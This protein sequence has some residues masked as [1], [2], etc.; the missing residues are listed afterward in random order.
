[1]SKKLRVQKTEEKLPE[2][3]KDSLGKTLADVLTA[4]SNGEHTREVAQKAA[5]TAVQITP[6]ECKKLCTKIGVEYKSGYESRV[7]AYVC[8]DESVDRYGDIIKQDGWDLTAFKS[9]PVV[10]GFHNY[11]TFPVGNSIKTWTEDNKLK[12]WILF[13]DKDVNEDA[14]IAFRMAKSGFMKAGSVGFIPKDVHHPKQEER[15]A[16]GMTPWGVVFQKQELLEHTVCGVPANS[17][18]LQEAV[19]KGIASQKE[20]ERWTRKKEPT[21]TPEPE[22]EVKTL[23]YTPSEETIKTIE[24]LM[25]KTFEKFTEEKAGAVLSK[26]NKQL[27]GNAIEAMAS[28]QKA[29]QSLL[30][31]VNPE[32][33]TEEDQKDQHSKDISTTDS[34]LL[35]DDE[36][37]DVDDM[38]GAITTL[39]LAT[40]ELKDS[41]QGEK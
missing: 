34:D 14:D 6:E 16:L 9:N 22:P 12:M 23:K 28:A 20:V 21:V 18:A 4:K 27:V 10:M 31:S 41:Q 11:G 3:I 19:N 2:F 36:T 35:E 38:Y 5:P 29:L 39:N 13:A 33:N 26:K 24:G 32:S 8:S 1:M 40:K 7:L 25:E 30:D 37:D 15:D 17:N